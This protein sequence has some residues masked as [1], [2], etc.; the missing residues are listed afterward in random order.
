MRI[1]W[2]SI[3]DCCGACVYWRLLAF[4]W[5][6][7]R[8]VEML[9][10]T[11]KSSKVIV[12]RVHTRHL[13]V[14]FNCSQSTFA[15][16]SKPSTNIV[17]IVTSLTWLHPYLH[18]NDSLLLRITF[19]NFKSVNPILATCTFP[20]QDIAL[21]TKPKKNMHTYIGHGNGITCGLYLAQKWNEF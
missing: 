4:L 10:D 8:N 7:M 9:L 14:W 18:K 6:L 20:H 15:W 16:V 13:C 21:C 12:M 19:K 17:A 1:C 11:M 3:F 2:S 5:A